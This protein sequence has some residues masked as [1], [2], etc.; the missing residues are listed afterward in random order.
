M[1]QLGCDRLR[2][3][4]GSGVLAGAGAGLLVSQP[5][6]LHVFLSHPVTS[7]AAIVRQRSILDVLEASGLAE[8]AARRLYAAIHTYTL[9]FA[10]LEASRLRWLANNT[11]TADPDTAWLAAMTSPRQFADGLG[12]MLDG[13]LQPRRRAIHGRAESGSQPHDD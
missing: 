5:A 8:Q 13:S 12:A 4:V 3:G 6:A 11:A 1:V 10:A 2:S 9:G 7:P